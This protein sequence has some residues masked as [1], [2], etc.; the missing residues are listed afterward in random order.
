MVVET[1]VGRCLSKSDKV[2]ELKQVLQALKGVSNSFAVSQNPDVCDFKKD[3][4]DLTAIAFVDEATDE[5]VA[6][7]KS[8]LD[9]M[10]PELAL[11]GGEPHRAE[12]QQQSQS[13]QQNVATLEAE[14][15]N[16]VAVAVSEKPSRWNKAAD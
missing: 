8:M 5:E 13:Q 12:S 1:I 15:N 11:A 2:N 16:N 14:D 9:I 3:V 7:A 4:A 10:V 6:K